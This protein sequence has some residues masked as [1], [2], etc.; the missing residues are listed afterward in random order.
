V[1]EGARRGWP[2]TE[3][4]GGSGAAGGTTDGGVDGRRLD[5]RNTG[6]QPLYSRRHPAARAGAGSGVA[7]AGTPCHDAAP[8][9]PVRV[10]S[11]CVALG[12]A[13]SGTRPQGTRPREGARRGA[14]RWY[15]AARRDAQRR[16]TAST[17]W[18]NF[19]VPLFER[20]K[21]QKF[22]Q[23]CSKW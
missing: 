16:G 11:R 2:L 18:K 21:L 5:A 8:G 6:Q 3:P 10:P 12:H 9:G 20:V 1:Q 19:T 17:D 4:A 23:K 7:V 15:D 22:V 13:A 14:G